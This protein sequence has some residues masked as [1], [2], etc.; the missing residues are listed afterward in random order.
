[1]RSLTL[2]ITL[3]LL[4]ACADEGGDAS[5]DA[6]AGATSGAM[7]ADTTADTAADTGAVDTGAADT[8][9]DT[10]SADAPP[11]DTGPSPLDESLAAIL[12]DL[13]EPQLPLEPVTDR[14]PAQ[15]ALGRALFFDPI[16]SGNKDIACATCHTPGLGTSDR[17][18]LSVG[19]GGGGLGAERAEGDYPGFVPR[20]AV[21]LFNRGDARWT[22]MFWDS[23]VERGE[24]GALMT[25]LGDDLPDGVEGV[26][27][28]QA[29]F[30]FLDRVEM[31]GQPG[32]VAA[33]GTANELATFDDDAPQAIFTAIVD[34]LR[35]LPGYVELFAA[36]WPDLAP[37]DWTIAHV[38]NA[39]AA[40]EAQ[41]FSFTDTP[42]DR[43]LR[44]DL[45]AISDVAKIGASVFFGSAGCG[46]CHSGP[47]LSDQLPHV[48][49][50]PQLGPGMPGDAPFDTGR[51]RVTGDPGDRFAFRT[52]PLRNVELSAPYMHN[53]AL[54][55][56]ERA[57]AHYASPDEAV[58]DLDEGSLHPDL[59][60][61]VQ[62]D[63]EHVADLSARLS[64]E[65]PRGTE[66]TV[67][68]SNV[69]EFLKALT[70][71]AARD[72][73]APPESVPSGL[74]VAGSP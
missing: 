73:G 46:N 60:G 58:A 35:A 24:G 2:A 57:V 33:D 56:L 3:L 12:A 68:L 30:P 55:T 63:A 45:S 62:R 18:N 52:P 15:V 59:R 17:L 8:A 74:P 31:L 51:E 5:P 37:E 39:I 54:P 40:Y 6:D 49:G 70:D 14:G 64:P 4:T 21:D 13:E 27:A 11:E 66:A 44:G 29:L 43:Y 1:M 42:W 25:P 65:M 50:I 69:R 38:V 10:A 41:A 47:L 26:L 61:T 67:G 34:R 48:T 71:P 36:A 20:H 28:A 9:A 53:G 22:T 72:P 32:D 16:L 7:D 19:T 23:R